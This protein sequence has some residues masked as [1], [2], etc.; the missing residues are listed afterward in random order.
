[1]T[2]IW[3][4]M[5]M[6]L[7]WPW[8]WVSK[9]QAHDY[10]ALSELVSGMP[11]FKIIMM[12][13]IRVVSQESIK[14]G[15][16]YFSLKYHNLMSSSWYI[17]IGLICYPSGYIAWRRRSI[18]QGLIIA[19]L[20]RRWNEEGDHNRICFWENNFA[21]RNKKRPSLLRDALKDAESHMAPKGDIPGK[22][23]AV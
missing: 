1:M 6:I 2:D 11:K 15:G 9:I 4:Y 10:K 3:Q 20:Q 12:A 16:L 5:A 21:G 7:E 18:F 19:P 8:Q 14:K 13:Y 23:E 22:Q 17:M